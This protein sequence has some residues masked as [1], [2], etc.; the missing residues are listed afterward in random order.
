MFDSKNLD[1]W[2]GPRDMWIH[3]LLRSLALINF[4]IMAHANVTFRRDGKILA[5]K[6]LWVEITTLPKGEY[7][8]GRPFIVNQDGRTCVTLLWNNGGIPFDPHPPGVMMTDWKR[9]FL[10]GLLQ[11]KVDATRVL[12]DAERYSRLYN[13][14]K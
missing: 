2:R 9:F 4:K 1:V 13:A 3:T 6:K 10:D 8:D 14:I 7:G 11:A 12:V 5:P